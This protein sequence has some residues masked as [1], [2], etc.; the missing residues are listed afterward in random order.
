M[1][2]RNHDCG[3]HRCNPDADWFVVCD[4]CGCKRCPKATDCR[5]E[6]TH[7]NEPGQVGSCFGVT[8][9]FWKSKRRRLHSLTF[10][11]RTLL[12]LYRKYYLVK[13]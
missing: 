8:L 10:L 2:P 4:V 13:P 12:K 6:C 9:D 3:C 5:H 7:S 1:T 11:D